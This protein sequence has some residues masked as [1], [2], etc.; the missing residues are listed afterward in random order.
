MNWFKIILL[1]LFAFWTIADLA[2]LRGWQPKSSPVGIGIDIIIN[3][4]LFLGIWFWL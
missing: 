1:V 4:L 2:R 3:I